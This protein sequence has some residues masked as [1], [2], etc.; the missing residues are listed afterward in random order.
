MLKVSCEFGERVQTLISRH[1]V[2]IINVYHEPHVLTL[3]NG[4]HPAQKPKQQNQ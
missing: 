1:F 4:G 2:K 3:R